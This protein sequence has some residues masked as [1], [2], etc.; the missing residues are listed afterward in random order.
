MLKIFAENASSSIS[1]MLPKMVGDEGKK[2]PEKIVIDK[3]KDVSLRRELKRRKALLGSNHP[4][5]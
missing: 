1:V 2:T 5:D 4:R 3:S